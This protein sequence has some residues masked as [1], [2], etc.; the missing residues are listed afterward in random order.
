MEGAKREE[1][2]MMG[3]KQKEVYCHRKKFTTSKQAPQV[4]V[5]ARELLLLRLVQRAQRCRCFVFPRVSR[6]FLTCDPSCTLTLRLLLEHAQ[7]AAR[8]LD[9]QK[10]NRH[11]QVDYASARMKNILSQV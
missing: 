9:M 1:R 4:I 5:R 8:H 11:L 3:A 2:V 10:D 7:H 6:R